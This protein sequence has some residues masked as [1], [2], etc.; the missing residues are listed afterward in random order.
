MTLVWEQ[1]F[2]S[3]ISEEVPYVVDG[4][5]VMKCVVDMQPMR[6]QVVYMILVV[7]KHH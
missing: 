4:V 3:V 6:E 2:K 7:R 1:V 5:T